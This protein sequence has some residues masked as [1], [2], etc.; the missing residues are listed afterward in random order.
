MLEWRQVLGEY[1]TRLNLLGI[2]KE[3]LVT[4]ERVLTA[5]QEEAR[6]VFLKR[7]QVS[8]WAVSDVHMTA[9][10]G[11]S[12]SNVY[13]GSYFL[14]GKKLPVVLKAFA[15]SGGPPLPPQDQSAKFRED[16]NEVLIM[17]S[18]S[19]R[20]D[21]ILKAFGYYT[22]GSSNV[23]MITELAPF[24]ALFPNV[25]NQ[26]QLKG[27]ISDALYLAWL[28]DIACALGSFFPLVLFPILF[29]R[30]HHVLSFILYLS[31]IHSFH[32]YLI[33]LVFNVNTTCSLH[34]SSSRIHP[35]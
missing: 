24:G 27:E 30:F 1:V 18:L 3:Y 19:S 35:L 10:D 32:S 12:F 7:L 34:M 14:H 17:S 11:G 4:V 16:E 22:D 6:D 28:H 5:E 29:T 20:S 13:R 33:Y 21:Y 9:F 26:F 25:L 8:N 23:T 15:I 2:N 31:S